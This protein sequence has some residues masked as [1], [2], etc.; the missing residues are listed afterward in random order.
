[1]QNQMESMWMNHAWDMVDLLPKHHI[2]RS[3]LVLKIQ[4]RANASIERYEARLVAKSYTQLKGIN[5]EKNASF[6]RYL[7]WLQKWI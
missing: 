5:Y 2:I 4:R 1:M 7:L 3:K 6:T